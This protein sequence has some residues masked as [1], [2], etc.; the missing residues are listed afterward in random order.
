[1]TAGR[2]T[3]PGGPPALGPAWSG[4]PS[5]GLSGLA[6]HALHHASMEAHAASSSR[7]GPAPASW[8]TSSHCTRAAQ[9]RHAPANLGGQARTAS[10]RGL[11]PSGP[12]AWRVAHSLWFPPCIAHTSRGSSSLGCG[13]PSRSC[14]IS[15]DPGP[16]GVGPGQRAVAPGP[17]GLYTRVRPPVP[18]NRA[19]P[20]GLSS[21]GSPDVE[22]Q[23]SQVSSVPSGAQ[24]PGSTSSGGSNSVR[25]GVGLPRSA[26][27]GPEASNAS[28]RSPPATATRHVRVRTVASPKSTARRVV[29]VVR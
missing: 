4:R 7:S 23:G 24:Q 15:M 9:L 22:M 29:I 2:G 12:T 16:P 17:S 5:V 14:Q 19:C 27:G 25:S 21:I 3:R 8:T 11:Y 13:C 20:A 26:R 18:G 28:G 1:M 6:C 10:C